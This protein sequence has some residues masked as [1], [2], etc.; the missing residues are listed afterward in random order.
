MQ[1]KLVTGQQSVIK[2]ACLYTP[3][4]TRIVSCRIEFEQ[5]GTKEDTVVKNQP[6]R[7]PADDGPAFSHEWWPISDD[8]LLF[9]RTNDQASA[10]GPAKRVDVE[11]TFRLGRAVDP[12]FRLGKRRPSTDPTFRLGRRDPVTFRLGKKRREDKM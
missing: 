8:H 3:S 1:I 12:T 10:A 11:P 9:R 6:R 4:H 2:R 7:A 5:V